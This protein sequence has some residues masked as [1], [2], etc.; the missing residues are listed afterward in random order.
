MRPSQHVPLLIFVFL[1]A[2]QGVCH[3]MQATND[4]PLDIIDKSV[5]LSEGSLDIPEAFDQFE[6]G[7]SFDQVVSR[8]GKPVSNFLSEGLVVRWRRNDGQAYLTFKDN[9]ITERQS[10]GAWPEAFGGLETFE[11]AV[12]LLGE[13]DGRTKSASYSWSDKNKCD[14]EIT[15]VHN[16]AASASFSCPGGKFGFKSGGLADIKF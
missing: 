3:A 10:F 13:P 11:Q 16:Q 2:F 1:L 4:A 7:A 12:K 5:A 15:F 14:L 8:F 9:K 6:L